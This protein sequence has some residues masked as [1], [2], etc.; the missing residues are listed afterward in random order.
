MWV[1]VLYDEPGE[2]WHERWLLLADPA[3]KD[4]W[5]VLTP[6]GDIYLEIITAFLDVVEG[7]REG[8]RRVPR[9]LGAS[10]GQP[11]YRFTDR[12]ASHVFQESIDIAMKEIVPPPPPPRGTEAGPMRRIRGKSPVSTGTPVDRPPE[13]E[14]APHATTPRAPPVVFGTDWKVPGHT[15]VAMAK[16]AGICDP[17]DIVS[18]IE[19]GHHGLEFGFGYVRGH[20]VSVR[21]VVAGFEDQM[22]AEMRIEWSSNL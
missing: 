3:Q 5:W 4:G 15:W 8:Q 1:Y 13:P 19:D 17:G 7:D 6:D 10:V 22:A 11:I 20:E 14:S 21:L 12:P 16:V 18:S 2:P 9:G